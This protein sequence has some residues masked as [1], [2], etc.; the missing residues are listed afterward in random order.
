MLQYLIHS[1]QNATITVW[2][3]LVEITQFSL[4]YRDYGGSRF[5]QNFGNSLNTT[6]HHIAQDIN[7]HVH[8]NENLKSF[9]NDPIQNK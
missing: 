4:L 6:Q 8:C 5:L 9:I 3:R 2:I 1:A 7:L